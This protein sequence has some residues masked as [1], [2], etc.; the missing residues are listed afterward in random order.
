MCTVQGKTGMSAKDA[1]EIFMR[2]LHSWCT[3]LP[4]FNVSFPECSSVM[5]IIQVE[6]IVR[7]ICADWGYFRMSESAVCS[8]HSW[9]LSET[10][11]LKTHC[12]S[13]T[14]ISLSML[15]VNIPFNA[16]NGNVIRMGNNRGNNLLC[17]M[18]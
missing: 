6:P 10:L 18:T 3:L 17:L 2:F 7:V 15:T 14:P 13:S 8:P 9:I 1:A 12:H 11:Q 16:L 5:L 4:G